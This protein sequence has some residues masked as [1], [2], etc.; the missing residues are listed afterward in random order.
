MVASAAAFAG[1]ACR[2]A[3]VEPAAS[4]AVVTPAPRPNLI[5]V[6]ADDMR[7]DAAGYTG[8]PIVR[9]PNLDDLAHRGVSFKNAYVTSPICAISR[10]SI[11]T[12]QYSRRHNILDFSMPLSSDQQTASYPALLRAAGYKTGFIGKFGVGDY[13]PAKL[14]DFWRGFAGQGFYETADSAGQPIHLTR[15]MTQQAI[16]VPQ[17]AAARSAVRSLDQLQGAACQDEGTRRFI[18]EAQDDQMYSSNFIPPPATADDVYWSGFPDFFRNNNLARD[19]WQELFSTPDRYQASVKG[20]YRLIS[21]FDRSVGLIRTALTQL[22]LADNTVI[23]FTSDNGFFLGELG[24]SHKWYGQEP[25]VRVPM[26]IYDPRDP[27]GQG[28]RV[29]ASIALNIDVA[30]LCSILPACRLQPACRGAAW[31]RRF[32]RAARVHSPTSSSSI[33]FRPRTSNGR[34]ASSA[35]DTNISSTSMWIPTT[36]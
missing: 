15:L 26:I 35:A 8:N 19:R 23:V 1:A 6:L 21:G 13:P 28:G 32:I 12:G 33:S 10:A 9:T 16:P 27:T 20:Y 11:F 30:Q 18:P 7:W 24:M 14:F 31:C 3:A 36:K 4:P 29:D 17:G 34:R 22:G 5:F 2:D 25:S